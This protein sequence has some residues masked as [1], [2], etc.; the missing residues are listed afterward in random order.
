MDSSPQ[1]PTVT[2][3]IRGLRCS[4]VPLESTFGGDG[5]VRSG[6][7]L[8]GEKMVSFF[9]HVRQRG[10]RGAELIAGT[11]HKKGVCVQ[12]RKKTVRRVLFSLPLSL[13]KGSLFLSG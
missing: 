12:K 6:G 5:V 9:F 8:V 7:R 11:G 4:E 3:Q 13:T 1:P 10:N 2:N